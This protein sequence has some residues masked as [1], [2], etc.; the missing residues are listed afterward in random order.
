MKPQQTNA[1]RVGEWCVQP[2]EGLISRNDSSI[3]VEVRAMRLLVYLA[4]RPGQ[5]VSIDE[6]L[7][8][9]W[10][11]ISVSPDSVYQAVASLRRLLGDEP[12][13]PRYIAT[14]PRLGYRMVASVGPWSVDSTHQSAK[15]VGPAPAPELTASPAPADL[16][17][18]PAPR[19]KILLA[20]AIGAVL[21]FALAAALLFRANFAVSP[22]PAAAS[23][24]A[25]QKSIA[26]LPF[27]DLTEGMNEEE[28]ADGMTE[29][30]IDKLSKMPNLR[31][32]APTSSFFYKGKQAPVADIAR[33][34]GVGYVVDGSVRKS[35]NMLRVAA[36]LVRADNGY[37]AWSETYDR[38]FIDRLM[39]QDEIAG[40][41]AQALRASPEFNAP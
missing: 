31:V 13:Q 5:V 18:N 8:H 10:A 36:R 37:V 28:F 20:A 26:V 21:C 19:N 12:K 34:L 2:A 38:P 39:V 14:V 33:S 40:K 16:A 23:T 32:P 15:Q 11:S 6:L 27:L 1:L 9:V 17:A 24:A 30:L 7:D 41:V 25:P 3:R 35:G 29:E 22:H 4:E